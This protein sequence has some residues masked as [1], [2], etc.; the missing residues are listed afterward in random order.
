MM[1]FID[2][3]AIYWHAS[4]LK[5]IDEALDCFRLYKVEIEN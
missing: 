3:A 5:T 4:L 1:T 2:D